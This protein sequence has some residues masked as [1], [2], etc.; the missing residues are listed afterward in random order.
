MTGD[1]RDRIDIANRESKYGITPARQ[2][3]IE[4]QGGR[5][6]PQLLKN[7]GPFKMLNPSLCEYSGTN[8][9]GDCI[10]HPNYAGQSRFYASLSTFT[11]IS[12]APSFSSY[13]SLDKLVFSIL[14]G[15]ECFSGLENSRKLSKRLMEQSRAGIAHP[16]GLC[17]AVGRSTGRRTDVPSTCRWSR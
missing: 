11:S 9:H 2:D 1:I 14:N 15:L 16:T 4:K 8:L 3:V 13:D 5:F 7:S 12:W 17:C 10:S 6:I